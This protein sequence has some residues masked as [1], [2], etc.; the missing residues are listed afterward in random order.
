[1]RL[2]RLDLTN[3]RNWE[4]R[5][6]EFGEGVTVLVGNN[7]V[8]K[9][10]ILEAIYLLATG[11]SFRAEKIE[12]MVRWQAEVAHVIGVVGLS[13]AEEVELQ[14]RLTRGMVQ[15]KRVQKRRFL[16]N[17]LGRRRSDFAGQLKAVVFRPEDLEIMTGSPGKRRRLMDQVLVQADRNY[18]RDLVSFENGI[19]RRNRVLVAIGEGRADRRALAFWD[20]LVIKHGNGLTEKRR[21]LVEEI[22]TEAKMVEFGLRL[23]Y[24]TSTISEVRLAQYVREEVA[25]GYT[26]VGPHRDDF[27]IV[28]SN[29]ERG[30][31]R[32]SRDLAVYGSRG[33]QRMAV[34]ELKLAMLRFMKM[35]TG[36]R[37]ILLLDDVFSELDDEHDR[38]VMGLVREQQT[39]ITT[40]EVDGR[41]E[42]QKDLSVVTL[43]D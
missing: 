9:T 8:G 25:A 22:N 34:L 41:F 30:I 16:V 40:T 5:Q 37:P 26:L 2:Q 17:G 13:T 20:Q 31:G 23:E 39:I 42:R 35:K 43:M 27:R 15:G 18:R 7:G 28:K 4:Q 24:E 19:K 21:E 1:M 6:W 33:E 36:E 3:W 38:L 12:E 29:L 32:Q 11:E 14:V 10:N